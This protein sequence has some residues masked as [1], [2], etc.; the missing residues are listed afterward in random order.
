[1]AKSEK[2]LNYRPQAFAMR[3]QGIQ[4][5]LPSLTPGFLFDHQLNRSRKLHSL[6]AIKHGT[7]EI[8]PQQVP[9][10]TIAIPFAH[11]FERF[12]PRIDVFDDDSFS[13]QFAIERLLLCRQRTVFTRLVRNAT[14]FVQI[15]QPLITTV[16][17]QENP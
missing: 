15:Q 6:L 12:D 11:Y 17:Q 14:I 7:D 13:R 8:H 2:V 5:P 9:A 10:T 3:T 16:R 1:M 4:T